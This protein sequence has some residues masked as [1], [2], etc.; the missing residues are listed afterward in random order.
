MSYSIFILGGII[1]EVVVIFLL[2]G[3]LVLFMSGSI[4]F[5]DPE[6]EKYKKDHVQHKHTGM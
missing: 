1:M 6:N 2:V 3:T 5:G 4:A